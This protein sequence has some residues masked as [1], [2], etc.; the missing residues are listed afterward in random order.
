MKYQQPASHHMSW[1]KVS[2]FS[3]KGQERVIHEC[4][5]ST[6]CQIQGCGTETANTVNHASFAVSAAYL[7]CHVHLQNNG[8]TVSPS[9]ESPPHESGTTY[10]TLNLPLQIPVLYIPPILPPLAAEDTALR[11]LLWHRWDRISYQR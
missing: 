9:P 4:A 5:H 1:K 3:G 11:R 10:K 8:N 6:V 7:S 2:D